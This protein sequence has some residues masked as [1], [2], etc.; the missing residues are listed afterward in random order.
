[1]GGI[2]LPDDLMDDMLCKARVNWRGAKTRASGEKRTHVVRGA[3]NGAQS[4]S[5]NSGFK[6]EDF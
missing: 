5:N 1:M 2:L 6:L 3:Q 4:T